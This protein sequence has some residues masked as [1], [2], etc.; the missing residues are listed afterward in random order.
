MAKKIYFSNYYLPNG[1]YNAE[2]FRH[3]NKTK[4]IKDIKSIA[5][6]YL[7]SNREWAH[8]YV[9]HLE[10]SRVIYDYT[11]ELRINGITIRDI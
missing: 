8:V 4:A 1:I 3:T 2:T 11:A 9:Y 5:R 6:A 10:K 7:T